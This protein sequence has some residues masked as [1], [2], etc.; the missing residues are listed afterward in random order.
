MSARKSIATVVILA[1]GL[2]TGEVRADCL[3]GH[4]ENFR[5]STIMH[6]MNAQTHCDQTTQTAEGAGHIECLNRCCPKGSTEC[7]PCPGSEVSF[8]VGTS[9]SGYTITTHAK[10]TPNPFIW[11]MAY[12]M[13]SVSVRVDADSV[14]GEMFCIYDGASKTVRDGVEEVYPIHFEGQGISPSVLSCLATGTVPGE[15]TCSLTASCIPTVSS[16][17]RSWLNPNGGS[18]QDANNWTTDCVPAHDAQRSD[19]ASF[20]LARGPFIP[21]SGSGATAGQW[22]VTNGSPIEFNGSGQSTLGT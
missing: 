16:A 4:L 20:A 18:Y 9:G 5:L 15:V 3:D 7:F 17:T 10:L 14:G 11:T 8:N 21:E 2:L 6:V 1:A 19:I 22:V 13:A 12:Q